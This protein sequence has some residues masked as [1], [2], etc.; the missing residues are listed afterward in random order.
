[1]H[2]ADRYFSSA[3]IAELHSVPPEDRAERFF[4]YWTLKESYI[5]ATGKGLSVPLEQFSFCL[6]R[7]G[8]IGLSFHQ[9]LRDD[10]RR[11]CCWLLQPASTHLVAVCTERIAESGQRIAARKV[12]PLV[13]GEPLPCTVV[14]KSPD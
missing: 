3:E 2:I 5:K 10:P 7:A 13:S 6:A 8:S 11:W 9:G 1:V 14:A 4:R 12:V